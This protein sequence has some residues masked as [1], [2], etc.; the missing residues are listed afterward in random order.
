MPPALIQADRR[1]GDYRDF[2]RGAAFR[3][4]YSGAESK[5]CSTIGPRLPSLSGHRAD[6]GAIPVLS[7]TEGAIARFEQLKNL[8]LN[9]KHMDLRIAAI[10]LEHGGTLVTRNLR[11]FRDV[12]SLAIEDW[13]A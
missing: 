9:V 5:G 13:S 6:A 2:R 7:F 11:D 10:T 12:P 1:A 4:V 3:L 8:K